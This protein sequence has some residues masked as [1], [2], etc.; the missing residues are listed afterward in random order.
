M[1]D[2]LTHFSIAFAITAPFLGTKKAIIAGIIALLPDID[3][4]THIHRSATHSTIIILATTIPIILITWEKKPTYTKTAILYTTALL[5]HPIL[6]MFQTYTPILYPLTA[7]SILVN[8]KAGIMV[9][10]TIKPYVSTVIQT[11]PTDFTPFKYLD[12]PLIMQETLIPSIIL[13]A[14]PLLYT[15]TRSKSSDIVKED[16][17]EADTDPTTAKTI[18]E[19]SI[20]YDD[21][22]IVIPTLNEAEAIGALI[23]EIKQEGYKN[24]LVVDGYSKD[25]TPEIAKE[26]GAKVIFQ[27]GKG[28][29]GAIKTA[30]ENVQTPYML[31]MDGDNTYDPKDI[32]KFLQHAK[33][34]DQIIGIRTNRKNITPLHRIGNYIITKT[35]NLLTGANLTDICSGMYLLKT[36]TART[37]E[38]GSTSFEVEAEIAIQ[39]EAEGKVTEIP[40]N[41]RKRIGKPKLSTIKH[42]TKIITTTINLARHYNPAFL[43]AVT[44][45][46]ALIPGTIIY[47]WVL[48]RLIFQ[49][50]WH[51]GWALL[52]TALIILGGQGLILST[53]AL[54]LKRMEKRITTT[55]KNQ[56]NKKD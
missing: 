8:V 47:L 16:I 4:L 22:T 6:D 42:G 14:T 3:A 24:I 48:Y 26:K 19:N 10:N 36:E 1:P 55:L 11:T 32:W 7:Y 13:I 27:H 33:N 46:T 49:N 18:V 2:P 30:I 43:I 53:I 38:I 31:I 20:P 21:V 29:A 50:A 28:K 37:L 15:L 45:A 12:A 40:I 41:Y 39:T 51:S 9:D 34:Y 52:G 44:T 54:L 5:T 25:G 23:E 56:N 17:I 35:F